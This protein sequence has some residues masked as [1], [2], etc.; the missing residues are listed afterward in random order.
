VDVSVSQKGENWVYDYIIHN[1]GDPADPRSS[2][3]FSFCLPNIWEQNAIVIG[4]LVMSPLLFSDFNA[5]DE[6]GQVS[7]PEGWECGE[8]N[9]VDSDTR[10]A[11][12]GLGWQTWDSVHAILPGQS[13]GG[14]RIETPF[15]PGDIE[16][17]ADSDWGI[18]KGP[19][20][21]NRMFAPMAA[22]MFGM[23]FG[24]GPGM[25]MGEEMLREEADEEEV[26]EEV[27]EP[28]RTPDM[29]LMPSTDTVISSQDI[30]SPPP[31]SGSI[32]APP[33][34]F[35][36]FTV[37]GDEVWWIDPAVA[38]GYDYHVLSGPNIASVQL[39]TGIGDNLYDLHLY[40]SGTGVFSPTPF[41]SISG[42]ET[43]D[44]LTAVT[45]L[46]VD[47]FRIMGIEPS[48]GLDPTDPTAFVT[49]LSFVAPGTVTISQTPIAVPE[50]G[51]GTL[52]LLGSGL[53]GLAL[54]RRRVKKIRRD[55]FHSGASK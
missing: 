45:P 11:G 51:T 15:K 13:K 37:V 21:Q 36:P 38:I 44:F 9:R 29:P 47:R 6:I 31:P 53:T 28:G 19:V 42:G 17:G 8:F 25:F 39:P 7:S 16:W 4:G 50:P 14:F 33:F 35:P 5:M 34:I 10:L 12:V 1:I 22:E 23:M 46:G 32:L 30:V 54:K 52:L 48:V 3:I 43:Y 55:S 40:D 2:S 49:G 24:M 27:P 41:T 20:P 26:I 18:I